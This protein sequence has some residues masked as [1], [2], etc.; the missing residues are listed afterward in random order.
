[1]IKVLHLFTTLNTG[2]VESFIYN[3][4]SHIDNKKIQFD[5]VVLGNEPGYMEPMFKKLNSNIYHIKRFRE[6]PIKHYISLSKIIKNGKYDIIH[7]H[8]YKSVLGLILAKKYKCKVRIIHSH[9]ADIDENIIQKILRKLLTFIANRNATDKFACGI[10]AAKWLYGEKE[11]NKGN[12]LVINNAI[13]L[14]KYSYSEEKRIKIQS[15]L[16]L[17]NKFT[18]GNVARLTEQKNQEFLLEIVRELI[19]KVPNATLLLVGDGEDEQK[20]KQKTKELKIEKNVKF[21][22]LRKDVSDLLSSFDVFLLPS[23]YE[24]LPVILAEVQAS[25]VPALVS[26]SITKEINITKNIYYFSLDKSPMEWRDYILDIYNENKKN[27]RNKINEKMK[28]G[29]YDIEYQ[30]N[31]LYEC[32]KEMIKREEYYFEKKIRVYK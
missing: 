13:D 12:I 1:M 20:L 30:A 17:A 26:D 16:N 23:K 4:Y 15:E 24:G 25:G 27:D 7:C 29:K 21:L 28:H 18:V 2:G 9:M 31:K 6:N 8:G 3:Y 22:G 32:Y 11:F 14:K 19:K 10:D 5:E